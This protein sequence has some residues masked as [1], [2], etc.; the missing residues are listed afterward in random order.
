MES[1]LESKKSRTQSLPGPKTAP[2]IGNLKSLTK[3]SCFYRSLTELSKEWGSAFKVTIPGES[4]V[5]TS[6]SQLTRELLIKNQ[7][8]VIK[9]KT[10]KEVTAM[11]RSIQ[12]IT[13]MDGE[14][15]EHF[16]SFMAP[17]FTK[18]KFMNRDIRL[19]SVCED[20]IQS[21]SSARSVNG[22]DFMYRLAFLAACELILSHS[23]N[24]LTNL[25]SPYPFLQN[26][27]FLVDQLLLRMQRTPLWKHLPIP[28]NFK[29]KQAVKENEEYW[30]RA[31]GERIKSRSSSSGDFFDVLLGG[32]NLDGS[33]MSPETIMVLAH[34]IIGGAFE[35]SAA[36]L[37]WGFYELA[38]NPQLQT[39]IYEELKGESI[40][41]SNVKSFPRLNSFVME[42]LR[43]YTPFPLYSRE[44]I[45]NIDVGFPIRKGQKIFFLI[46]RMIKDP[47]VWGDDGEEFNPYRF[48]DKEMTKEQKQSLTPFGIGKRIC[49]GANLADVELPF[50]FARHIQELRVSSTLKEEPEGTLK[51]TYIP[52]SEVPLKFELIQNN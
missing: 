35:S 46:G 25:G 12:S 32:T 52:A 9:G 24:C 48:L 28:A 38:K 23:P 5:V 49:I 42:V 47:K 36:L 41:F 50:L 19:E 44:V 27:L 30:L 37:T 4:W 21:L 29:V 10:L 45:E 26:Q 31:L 6:D 33:P 15:W 7:S 40:S 22:Y 14:K 43:F 11:S 16:R 13:E 18:K 2:F 8:K 34:G 20:S 17:Y 3:Y 39:E 1:T 51:F